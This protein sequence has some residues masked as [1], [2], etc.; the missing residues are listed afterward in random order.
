MDNKIIL[1]VASESTPEKEDEFNHWYTGKHVPMM[2][3]SKAIKK[4]ARYQLLDTSSDNA[5]YI[6]VYEF[7]NE[8]GFNAFENSPELND[9]KKDFDE[10]AKN[11]G[12]EKKWAGKYELI[13]CWEK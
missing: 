3:G 12:F 4:A 9:A 5:K 13:K 2:F 6:A 11:I 7:D 8:D 1:I 10:N